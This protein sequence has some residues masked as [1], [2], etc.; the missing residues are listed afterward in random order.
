MILFLAR[1]EKDEGN[2]L[3]NQ[4][5]AIFQPYFFVH[6]SKSKY[7]CILINIKANALS[8]YNIITNEFISK[9]DNRRYS[10]EKR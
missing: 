10:R 1:E 2:L 9:K 7:L 6:N 4:K 8:D 5:Q 3:K